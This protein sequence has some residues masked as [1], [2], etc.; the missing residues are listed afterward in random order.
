MGFKSLKLV[1]FRQ[2]NFERLQTLDDNHLVSMSGILID[3]G[4]K[5]FLYKSKIKRI[6]GKYEDGRV[7]V[8]VMHNN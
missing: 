7:E 3:D 4:K 5:T 8:K 1:Y 6:Q 2:I